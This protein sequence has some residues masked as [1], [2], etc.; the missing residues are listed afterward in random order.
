M[1]ANFKEYS[2]LTATSLYILE[3]LYKNH[4][5]D[6]IQNINI[7]NYNTRLN[8]DCHVNFCRTTL[9]KRSVVNMG[10]ELYSRV[11]NNIKNMEGFLIFKKEFKF[12]L[13]NHSFYTKIN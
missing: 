7:H 1:Q 10:T 13:L 8:K 9:L 3:V 5:A 4:K 2:I 11:P 6:L 12:F